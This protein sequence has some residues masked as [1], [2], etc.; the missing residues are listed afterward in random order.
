[1]NI[2]HKRNWAVKAQANIKFTHCSAKP[3]R[4]NICYIKPRSTQSYTLRMSN[5]MATN[6]D[7]LD[8]WD[9]N[10]C[11]HSY[12]VITLSAINLLGTKAFWFLEI[13][14]SN[15]LSRFAR[16][17][18]IMRSMALQILIGRNS[19]TRHG[20]LIFGIKTSTALEHEVNQESKHS[21]YI[22]S[23]ISFFVKFKYPSYSVMWYW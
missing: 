1:M 9:L 13:N 16:T 19:E 3:N 21:R 2:N 20:N 5:F 22:L 14:S 7:F 10:L 11:K 12:S 8:M 18:A 17:L 23:P 6:P 4:S 15:T